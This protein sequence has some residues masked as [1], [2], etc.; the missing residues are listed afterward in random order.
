MAILRTNKIYL[1]HGKDN[2]VIDY[3]EEGDSFHTITAQHI[4]PILEEA[5]L[6]RQYAGDGFSKG[7]N[8][9]KVAT[10]PQI[11][12]L[13]HPELAYD[14]KAL[15]KFLKGEGRKYCTVTKGIG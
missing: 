12:F 1:P 13:L 4:D 11:E 2:A 9:Q 14:E 15:I 8:M 5:Y 7:R 3:R 6:H 10:I